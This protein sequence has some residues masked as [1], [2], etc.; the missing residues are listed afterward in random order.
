M[1]IIYTAI[2]IAIIGVIYFEILKFL[3]DNSSN[4]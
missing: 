3:W 1:N 2:S 4:K